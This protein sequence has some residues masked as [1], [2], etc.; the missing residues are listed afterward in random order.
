MS[1]T[2]RLLVSGVLAAADDAVR[3]IEQTMLVLHEHIE[4]DLDNLDPAER[5]LLYA[6]DA[7]TFAVARYRREH[8]LAG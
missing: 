2:A 6:A 3:L 7:L 8:D 4:P 1:P 5:T